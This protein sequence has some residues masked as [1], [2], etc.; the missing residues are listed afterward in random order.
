MDRQKYRKLL[1]KLNELIS[2]FKKNIEKKE[3]EVKRWRSGRKQL[4]LYA[5]AEIHT[6]VNYF[7]QNKNGFLFLIYK[8]IT[9]FFDEKKLVE[10]TEYGDIILIEEGA[11]ND[12]LIYQIPI[13]ELH[14]IRLEIILSYE[15]G[16]IKFDL[17]AELKSKLDRKINFNPKEVKEMSDKIT[18][19]FKR[20]LEEKQLGI[21]P[22]KDKS[23]YFQGEIEPDRIEEAIKNFMKTVRDDYKINGIHKLGSIKIYYSDKHKILPDISFTIHPQY[24]YKEGTS[25]YVCYEN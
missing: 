25:V 7:Q 11:N 14:Q 8:Y 19:E 2:E 3:I 20:F 10:N 17:K 15:S 9:N 22:C 18:V 21:D 13:T 12:R 23:I 5:K 24:T 1:K 6:K 16:H 4:G